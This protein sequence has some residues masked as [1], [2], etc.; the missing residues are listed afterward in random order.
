ME[1]LN[2]GEFPFPGTHWD[3]CLTP[4]RLITDPD[5][6]SMHTQVPSRLQRATLVEHETYPHPHPWILASVL[7]SDGAQLFPECLSP[8]P[9]PCFTCS[10]ATL[11]YHALHRSWGLEVFSGFISSRAAPAEEASKEPTPASAFFTDTPRPRKAKQNEGLP[12]TAG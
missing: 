5:L 4:P 9:G 1:T 10:G 6:G 11:L 12:R 8:S 3:A 2:E 7:C